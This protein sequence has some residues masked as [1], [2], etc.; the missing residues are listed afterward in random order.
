M[1]AH[2]RANIV[3]AIAGNEAVLHGLFGFDPRPD[4]S[5]RWRP[6]PCPVDEPIRIAGYVFRGHRIDAEIAPGGARAWVDGI[7]VAGPQLLAPEHLPCR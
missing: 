1:P 2:K 3:A 5:L 6:A 7:E 4:G